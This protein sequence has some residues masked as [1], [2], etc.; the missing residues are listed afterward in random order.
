MKHKKQ[1][2]QICWNSPGK[3]LLRRSLQRDRCYRKNCNTRQVATVLKL[4]PIGCEPSL[5]QQTQGETTQNRSCENST[6]SKRKLN[7]EQNE[8]PN[9]IIHIA[10]NSTPQANVLGCDG[11]GGAADFLQVRVP[12]TNTRRK[13]KKN[14]GRA[15][16]MFLQQTLG[17]YLSVLRPMFL[18]V[19]SRF[20]SDVKWNEMKS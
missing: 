17:K 16:E 6:P 7:W 2:P 8:W 18:C 1:E 4:P 5:T 11:E 15:E 14:R 13:S 9:I 19:C 12:P 20:V 3:K 10:S